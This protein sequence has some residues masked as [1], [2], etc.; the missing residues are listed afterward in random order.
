MAETETPPPKGKQSFLKKKVA[1]VPMPVVLLG[2]GVVLYLVYRKYKGTSSTSSTATPTAS[3]GAA[4]V[5]SGGVTSGGGYTDPGA[6]NLPTASTQSPTDTS[7]LTPAP[8]ATVTGTSSVTPLGKQT[9]TV[10]GKS[11]AT[12]ANFSQGG[13]TYYGISN[14]AEAKRLQAAGAHLIRNPNDPNGKGLFLAVPAGRTPAQVVRRKS[15]PKKR[16]KA[17]VR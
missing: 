12:T 13:T 9:I 8:P 1:G 14:L 5:D 6:Y 11:F 2:G 7:S 3:S 16:R 4:P 17:K 15:A 10:G